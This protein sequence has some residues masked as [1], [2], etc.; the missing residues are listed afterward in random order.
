MRFCL[1]DAVLERS[2]NRIVTLKQVSNAEE[3]LLDHFASFPVLPGVFMIESLVQAARLLAE[4][5]QGDA[6]RHV[7]GGVRGIK[8]GSFVRPGDGL[9]I[10]VN[11]HKELEGGHL[12]FKG[13]GRVIPPSD[14]GATATESGRV[15]VSGRFVLRPILLAGA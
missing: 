7:L 3:Y 6:Q 10:E 15:A 14:R 8:Y 5:R 9:R 13:E 12:E 4:S 11:F 2:T 1:V